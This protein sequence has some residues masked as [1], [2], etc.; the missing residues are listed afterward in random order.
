MICGDIEPNPGPGID[1]EECCNRIAGK[2]EELGNLISYTE[3]DVLI[4]TETKIDSSIRCSEFLP[5][6]Y[7]SDIRKDQVRGGGGVMIAIKSF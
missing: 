5:S 1:E 2:L 6:N 4:L 3:P 7:F